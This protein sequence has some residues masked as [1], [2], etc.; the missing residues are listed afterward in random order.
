[1]ESTNDKVFLQYIPKPSLQF[2]W[3]NFITSA[4]REILGN[5]FK[6]FICRANMGSCD[7]HD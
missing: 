6:K 7:Q 3:K 1:M 5:F 4:F 2:Y